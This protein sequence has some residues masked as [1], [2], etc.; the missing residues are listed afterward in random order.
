MPTQP[1]SHPLPLGLLTLYCP[2]ALYCPTCAGRDPRR[3]L[4]PAVQPPPRAL[5]VRGPARLRHP[6]LPRPRR[7]ARQA[8]GAPLQPRGLSWLAGW[9]VRHCAAAASPPARPLPHWQG[10]PRGPTSKFLSPWRRQQAE[11]A[12]PPPSHSSR[13]RMACRCPITLFV[14]S[15]PHHSPRRAPCG[16]RRRAI[17][18]FQSVPVSHCYPPSRTT[19]PELPAN[20][21]AG[22]RRG[23]AAPD[24]SPLTDCAIPGL[25]ICMPSFPKFSATADICCCPLPAPGEPFS[26][27][28][29]PPAP[30]LLPLLAGASPTPHSHPCTLPASPLPPLCLPAC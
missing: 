18:S 17:L 1:P 20:L 14:A 29:H 27:W 24:P 19:H 23:L 2:P 7:A 11:P 26:R 6:F 12:C 21:P 3:H 9:R 10:A 4:R 15:P 5:P 16:A 25:H 30:R 22:G 28:A 13:G 8:A